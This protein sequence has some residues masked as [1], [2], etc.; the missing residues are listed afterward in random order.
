MPDRRRLGFAGIVSVALALTDRGELVGDPEIEL[1]GIPET[2]A[3]GNLISRLAF[4][5]VLDAIELDAAGAP[6]R[7]GCGGG[8]G[9]ARG[10]RR[11]RLGLEQEAD[12]PCPCADG[13]R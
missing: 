13:V 5:A 11:G 7:S 12:V 9:A 6:A 4:D 10:A 3:D 1:T 8:G 2:D